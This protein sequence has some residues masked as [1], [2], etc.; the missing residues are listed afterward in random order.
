MPIQEYDLVAL[1]E[2]RSATNK[3][4]QQP[5]LLRRGQ[6]GT[7]LML[8][9]SETCLIDFADAQGS[10][11]AMENIPVN[12]LLPLYHDPKAISA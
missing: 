3:S 12:H 11:Y 4:T 5:I 2:D 1:T 8:L 9:D 6:I 7:V 10:T